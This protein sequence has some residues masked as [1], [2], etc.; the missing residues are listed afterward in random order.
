MK[1]QQ[2]ISENNVLKT[3]ADREAGED[4]YWNTRGQNRGPD[5]I[6]EVIPTVNP[7]WGDMVSK[8]GLV[9]KTIKDEVM[10]LKKLNSLAKF[11][12]T[13]VKLE[14]L[15]NEMN[16]LCDRIQLSMAKLKTL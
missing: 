14:K 13:K 6:I 8:T 15:F 2:Y 10:R 3:L 16:G 7:K 1:M 11:K 5:L 9:E 12:A 4:F